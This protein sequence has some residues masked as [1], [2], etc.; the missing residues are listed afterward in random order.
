[1]N[2]VMDVVYS[3]NLEF[4]LSE[5]PT[6]HLFKL[7]QELNP[8]AYPC[9]VFA[10]LDLISHKRFLPNL[11]VVDGGEH[12]K[13]LLVSLL[14]YI[15]PYLRSGALDDVMKQLYVG[16]LRL[17]LW[18]LHDGAELLANYYNNFCDVIPP[19]AVQLRNIILTA[20]LPSI[21]ITH[22]STPAVKI[23]T[24][25]GMRNPPHLPPHCVKVL[26]DSHIITDLDNFLSQDTAPATFERDLMA[27]LQQPQQAC[28]YNVPALNA[29][30]L[31]CAI[32]VTSAS[33]KS[34]NALALFK[35]LL[36]AF[37]FE[38]RMLLF[39][40]M[41]N[42]LRFPN[43]HTLFYIHVLLK[44]FQSDLDLLIKH[45]LVRTVTERLIARPQP[46][47]LMAFY[48]ELVSDP[49]FANYAMTLQPEVR[50]ILES[51]SKALAS[52]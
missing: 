44:L 27:L 9:F 52:T 8:S 20:L 45:Q 49:E 47:G 38:G 4:D 29:L 26:E 41:F 19:N 31:Q 3:E 7:L 1:L 12:A 25:P 15:E 16:A 48:R 40:A 17:F 21:K 50:Q 35:K 46:W 18:L 32:V 37:D 22:F 51:I 11:L 23:D 5:P 30:V 14:S 2:M 39:N 13:D 42:Q 28:K 34:N 6:L 33:G 36:V 24:V 10:W 43:S